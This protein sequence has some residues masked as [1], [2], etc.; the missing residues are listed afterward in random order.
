MLGLVCCVQCIS[1]LLLLVVSTSAID[2]LERLVSEMTF[3]VSCGMLIPT[4]S[5]THKPNPYP[6][7]VWT[8]FMRGASCDCCRSALQCL[9]HERRALA[10]YEQQH[11]PS[12][13]RGGQFPWTS[14]YKSSSVQSP[15]RCLDVWYYLPNI[16]SARA[17]R[18]YTNV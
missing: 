13:R 8:S 3:Y 4:H 7:I 17:D 14:Y 2:C 15:D 16:E 18:N 6:C 5:L 11:Q 12:V 10:L 1:Y 9:T